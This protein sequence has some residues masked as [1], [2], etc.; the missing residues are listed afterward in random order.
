VF[1]CRTPVSQVAGREVTTI[2]GLGRGGELHPVQM[3]FLEEDAFQCAYCTSGM[4]VAAVALLA[5]NPRPDD[6]Q[7]V[8]ALDG[9]LCRCCAYPNILRAVR[10]AAGRPPEGGD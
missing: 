8:A 5:E 3:A 2:E 4:V 1:S 6:A 9:N 7:I 10:R